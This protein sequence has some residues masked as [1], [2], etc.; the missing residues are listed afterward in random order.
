MLLNLQSSASNTSNLDHGRDVG[1]DVGI[2]EARGWGKVEKVPEIGRVEGTTD[3]ALINTTGSAH[4][5]E[6]EDSKPE[7]PVENLRRVIAAVELEN[8]EGVS[9]STHDELMTVI[10]MEYEKIRSDDSEE[11]GIKSK[12]KGE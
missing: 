12:T 9:S 4:D 6:G 10:K 7:S 3:Q 8:V 2:L 5:T 11:D 1:L